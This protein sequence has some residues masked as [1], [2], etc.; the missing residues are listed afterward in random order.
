[1]KTIIAVSFLGI[2]MNAVAQESKGQGCN[3]TAMAGFDSAK[4]LKMP[5]AYQTHTEK[6]PSPPVVCR[7][8]ETKQTSDGKADSI[9]YEFYRYGTGTSIY[10]SEEHC[11]IDG[12]SMK[13]G[14]F[15]ADCS[16]TNDTYLDDPEFLKDEVDKVFKSVIDTD[17]K[18][19]AILYRC[20]DDGEH[21][22]FDD[23]LV[24]KTD[25]K[26]KNGPI[27]RALKKIRKDLKTFTRRTNNAYCDKN[28]N[29]KRKM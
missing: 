12:K 23:I 9:T 14:Q 11:N 16:V 28:L 25:L 24:L 21:G 10:Y 15:F 4:Y 13:G 2:V 18:N 5:P 26:A 8:T 6:T 7:I 17:Y 22:I 27:R 19:Y 1:M 3:R 29:I 20:M